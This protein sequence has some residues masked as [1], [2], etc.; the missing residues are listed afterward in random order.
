MAVA[1]RTRDRLAGEA[2]LYK[3]A[4][5]VAACWVGYKGPLEDLAIP[6]YSQWKRRQLTDHVAQLKEDFTN[7][8][9]A[10][11]TFRMARPSL[12]SPSFLLP[13]TSRPRKPRALQDLHGRRVLTHV[14]TARIGR[15]VEVPPY[16][17]LLFQGIH[18]VAI[19]KPEYMLA[20][21]RVLYGLYSASRTAVAAE[22][23]L[24]PPQWA[25]SGSENV[26]ALGRATSKHA[27]RY[28]SRSSADWH[29][30]THD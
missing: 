3:R 9:S 1:G 12:G 19:R 2:E 14:R 11:V 8:V 6:D 24:R 7:E 28:W 22:N 17:E 5:V 29:G 23:W 13:F 30:R 15:R 26:Q 4:W 18:G 20:R 27:S 25:R 10:I 21:P 16:A